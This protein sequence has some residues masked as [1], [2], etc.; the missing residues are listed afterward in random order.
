MPVN[1]IIA[2]T[3]GIFIGLPGYKGL[4]MPQ[5]SPE[6]NAASVNLI[7]FSFLVDSHTNPIHFSYSLDQSKY[8][9]YD[10]KPYGPVPEM[11]REPSKPETDQWIY[12]Y[13]IWG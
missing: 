9:W 7:R 2:L 6:V 3:G 10:R 12:Y 4:R 1:I 5:T 8:H 11:N 13:N